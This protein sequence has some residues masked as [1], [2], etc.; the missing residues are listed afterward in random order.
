VL[1]GKVSEEQI[2]GHIILVG[3]SAQ[4]LM[5]LRFNPMG[6]TM[7]GVEAHAQVLEQILTTTARWATRLILRPGSKASTNTWAP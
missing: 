4:G 2:A 3:A 7:P 6:T 1:A 5:D